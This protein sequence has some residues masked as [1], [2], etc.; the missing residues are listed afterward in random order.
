MTVSE[1][2]LHSHLANA[3]SNEA[4]TIFPTNNVWAATGQTAY[5][6]SINTTK[7]VAV[8]QST[9]GGLAHNNIQPYLVLNYCIALQGV[10]PSRN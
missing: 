8:L 10:F 4:N 3:S 1:I 7:A 5:H 6:Q 2:P 9:G